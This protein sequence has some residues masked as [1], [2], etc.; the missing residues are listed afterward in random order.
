MTLRGFIDYISERV[1]R[2]AGAS[3]CANRSPPG[4]GFAR[5]AAAAI[6]GVHSGGQQTVHMFLAS[7]GPREKGDGTRDHAEQNV[8]A[9]AE[10]SLAG[11][12]ITPLHL[13]SSLAPCQRRPP[14]P[15]HYI[16]PHH[17]ERA[18]LHRQL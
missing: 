17:Q 7:K 14:A 10:S 1:L 16:L 4:K 11:Y 3:E 9:A 8:V 18:R 15:F 6:Y 2:Q 13:V 12:L 5:V